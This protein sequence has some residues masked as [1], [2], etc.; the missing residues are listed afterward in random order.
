MDE[1]VYWIITI[2]IVA[3][4]ISGLVVQVTYEDIKQSELETCMEHCISMYI[5]DS[6]ELACTEGCF[7][8]EEN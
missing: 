3:L 4:A 1:G 7:V 6:N 8:M 5:E 2:L